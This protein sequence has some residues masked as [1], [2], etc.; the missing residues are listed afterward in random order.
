MIPRELLATARMP[1]NTGELRC[2]RHDGDFAIWIGGT[3]LMSSPVHG[4]EEQMAELAFE[5]LGPRPGSQVLVGG[6]G[7]GFTLARTLALVDATAVVEVAELVPAVVEWN[8]ELIGHCAGHPLRDERVRL[9]VGDVR[10]RI[11]GKGA[12]D[13]VLLDVDN[14]PEGLSRRANDAIYD[15]R[16]LVALRASLRAGGVLAVWSSADDPRFAGRLRRANF[17]VE[18]HHV[19]A[20]RTK[21]P[22]RTI[23]IAARE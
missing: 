4:S 21:G 6:L 9:F 17:D 7:M 16:S 2:Y 19:R 3:E 14:G 11:T 15:D 10:E 8:R 5:R 18:T 22:R 13:V 20:R 23:W 12:Y 1:G